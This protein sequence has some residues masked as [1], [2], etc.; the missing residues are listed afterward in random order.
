MAVGV[1]NSSQIFPPTAED[2]ESFLQL[3]SPA[4][5]HTTGSSS[6]QNAARWVT[7]EMGCSPSGTACF[8]V[9]P[10]KG[11]KSYQEASCHGSAGPCQEPVPAGAS[12]GLTASSEA[13]T[14]SSLGVLCGLQGNLGFGAWSTSCP[15]FSTD[16]DVSYSS[17]VFSP[18]FSL[19]A[20]TPAQK[21]F[22][23]P[24]SNKLS[25]RCSHHSWWAQPWLAVGPSWSWH[26]L[27]WT[28]RKLPAASH[29]S[30]SCSTPATKTYLHKPNTP[31]YWEQPGNNN[32]L[33]IYF[34]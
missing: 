10:P 8:S 9:G 33:K 31:W 24:F 25:Q 5:V 28:W 27:C 4:W 15:S 32:T 17:H 7:P 12:H 18:C 19:P 34:I 20:V 13:S 22:F 3:T 14:C 30:H 2:E 11:N 26:W 16:L 1:I 23:F 29:G 6:A 21:T